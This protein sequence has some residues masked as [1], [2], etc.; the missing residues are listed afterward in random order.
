MSLP[1]DACISVGLLL[2]VDSTI[3]ISVQHV[4]AE[5]SGLGQICDVIAGLISALLL[6]DLPC[7]AV[8]SGMHVNLNTPGPNTY[9]HIPYICSFAISQSLQL[10]SE[11]IISLPKEQ[12]TENKSSNSPEPSHSLHIKSSIKSLPDRENHIL[13]L[14]QVA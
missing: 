10:S 5:D 2:G 8:H 11:T 13:C 1:E 9:L 14:A 7:R 4:L 6:V 3:Q 12:T